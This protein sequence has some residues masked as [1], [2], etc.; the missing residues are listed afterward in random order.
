[1]RDNKETWV[2]LM[3]K[4]SGALRKPAQGLKIV[5]KIFFDLSREKTIMFAI[6]L[7]LF[8]ILTASLLLTNS[9]A[10]FSPDN[11]LDESITIAITGDLQTARNIKE[12]F[13]DSEL[14]VILAEHKENAYELFA[15]E[16][17]NAVI[18][19]QPRDNF[20]P[21]YIDLTLPKGDIKSSMILAK[22]KERLEI[23]E[24][25]LRERNLAEPEAIMLDRIR[26]K[27][28]SNPVATQIFEALYSLIIPFLLLM[29][30][31]LLGGLVIDILIEELEKKTLNL[32]MLIIS[33]RRYI[34]EL[35]I[36]TLGISMVQVVA[37][38]FL[39]SIQGIT[40]SNLPKITMIII[41]LNL[42]MFIF[43]VI[44]TLAIMD[45]TKAQLTYSFLVL[46]LFASMPLFDVN[47]IRIISRLAIGLEFVPFISYF[48]SLSLISIILFSGMMIVIKGKEW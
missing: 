19:I 3:P 26:I 14:E 35:I 22:I 30:G 41:M 7:Q 2:K 44:L 33:F 1:M 32:L 37:W 15:L 8:I 24:T 45:K 46:L 34:F 43:C 25:V 17:I 39:L 29:P 31:I 9:M 38:Q 6:F 11:I 23:Y 42:I 5:K 20:L 12:Y 18:E 4:N 27:E 48:L 10:I 36:A 47:P 16:E 40:I 28:S 13:K 21:I